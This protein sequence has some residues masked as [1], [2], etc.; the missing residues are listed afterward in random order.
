MEASQ[1]ALHEKWFSKKIRVCPSSLL[2]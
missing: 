1:R 2:H